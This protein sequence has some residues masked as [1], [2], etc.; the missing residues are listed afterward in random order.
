MVDCQSMAT[1]RLAWQVPLGVRVNGLPCRCP[2]RGHPVG[3]LPL[4]TPDQRCKPLRVQGLVAC[5][6]MPERSVVSNV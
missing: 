1:F 5:A 2:A 6:R 3:C 4:Q